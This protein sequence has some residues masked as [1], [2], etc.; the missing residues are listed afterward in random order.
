MRD[1][2]VD[3]PA[4]PD[5]GAPPYRVLFVCTANICRSVYADVVA[6]S[7]APAGVEFSSAGVRAL[8]GEGIDQ[9]MAE[10]VAGRGDT[11][12]HRARQLTRE[13]LADADLIIAMAADHRRY[14]L[15][16]WPMSGHKA[17]V[18]GH[19]A[20][21]MAHLP[22]T[23]TLDAL[24]DHLWQHRTTQPGDE[25]LDPYGRGQAAAGTAARAIDEH[26]AAILK[27]LNSLVDRASQS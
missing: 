10:Q 16:E 5:G 1:L 6:N 2:S 17:F 27:G 7:A 25:V 15:D 12:S 20:R 13:L 24:V 18:I 14:I 3:T 26:L 23:V 21:E 9:P 22:P 8:V 19:V 11:G 4:R